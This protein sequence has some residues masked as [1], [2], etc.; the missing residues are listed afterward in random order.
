MQPNLAIDLPYPPSVNHY[1]RR[2]GTRT[3]ISREG[4]RHRRDVCAALAALGRAPMTGR[5]SVSIV[6]H[7]PDRRR[8]DLDNLAKALLDALEHAGAYRDDSQIDLLSL[9]RGAV[10]PR[11]S[12]AVEI[13]E[14]SH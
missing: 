11:G 7:P 4:R 2:V 3:L 8:R 9:E 10:I 12:V 13:T 5:L 14:V 6:V 1:W